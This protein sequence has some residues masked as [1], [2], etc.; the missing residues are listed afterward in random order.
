MGITLSNTA[1][2]MYASILEEIQYINMALGNCN[3]RGPIANPT[4]P[5]DLFSLFCHNVVPPAFERFRSIAPES[6]KGRAI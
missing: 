2:C 3:V 4:S 5:N 1:A 6:I